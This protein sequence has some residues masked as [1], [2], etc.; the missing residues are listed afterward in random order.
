M[1]PKDFITA[2]REHAPWILDAQVE[3]DLVLPL[4]GQQRVSPSDVVECFEAYLQQSG[5]RVSRAEF[6][7]NL[8]AKKTDRVFLSDMRSL[9]R[10]DARDFDTALAID[11]VLENYV[12]LLPGAPWK[13]EKR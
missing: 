13:G 3:Q 8:A 7:A 5:L 10:Q 2:W 9:L 4:T 1:I 11:Q 6:E 12:S